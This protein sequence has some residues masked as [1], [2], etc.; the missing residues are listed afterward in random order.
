MRKVI[1]K[2]VLPRFRHVY[3]M[4]SMFLA[5]NTLVV[6]CKERIFVVLFFL[7]LGQNMTQVTLQRSTKIHFYHDF[8]NM[9]QSTYQSLVPTKVMLG[10]LGNRGYFWVTRLL[11]P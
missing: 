10:N 9:L 4:V 6:S 1:T 5:N 8:A 2:L 3:P 7:Y 11:F